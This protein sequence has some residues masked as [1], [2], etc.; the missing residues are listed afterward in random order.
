[1]ARLQRDASLFPPDVRS[2]LRCGSSL[3]TRDT[4]AVVF[5]RWPGAVPPCTDPQPLHPRQAASATHLEP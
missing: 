1:M 3:V 4:K 2:S 5:P